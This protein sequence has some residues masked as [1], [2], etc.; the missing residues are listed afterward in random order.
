MHQ[1]YK[2]LR[3]W[4]LNK[5]KVEKNAREELNLSLIIKK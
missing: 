2:F 4:I 5:T 1:V 3:L